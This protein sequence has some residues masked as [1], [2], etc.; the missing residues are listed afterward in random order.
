MTPRFVTAAASLD[1]LRTADLFETVRAGAGLG[2]PALL[3]RHRARLAASARAL[4]RPF[5]PDAFDALVRADAAGP[6]VLLR[7][8]LRPDGTLHAV[9]RPLGPLPTPLRIGDVGV[10]VRSGD[11][12]L[13]H[14]STLRAPYDAASGAARAAGL[15]EGVLVNER[16]EATETSRFSLFVRPERG[17]LLTPPVASGLLPG[18]LRAALLA[19]GEAREAVLTLADLEAAPDV[20]VGNAARGLLPAVW[21]AR[22]G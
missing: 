17:P 21:A 15:D 3:D 20:V 19:S 14:K 1:G 11:L 8:A 7:V 22:A 16:G 6:P 4:G 12:G 18:V 13:R 9:P 2:P 10:R 5:D